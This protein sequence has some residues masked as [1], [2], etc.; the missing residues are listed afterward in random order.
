MTTRSEAIEEQLRSMLAQHRC[1]CGH[2]AC[3]RCLDTR[4]VE[5]ALAATEV[6]PRCEVGL[7]HE[8]YPCPVPVAP[9]TGHECWNCHKPFVLSDTPTCDEC[10]TFWEEQ[11]QEHTKCA[12]APAKDGA[13]AHTGRIMGKGNEYVHCMECG[14]DWMDDGK[15]WRM[16]LP[17]APAKEET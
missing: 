10:A 7:G 14:M 5:A 16:V 9:L 2:P 8:G 13:C 12:P 4:D 11:A 1:D 15:G 3:Q 6:C 17:P